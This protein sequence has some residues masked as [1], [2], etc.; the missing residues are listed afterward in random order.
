M[1]MQWHVSRERE[2][3]GP[4]NWEEFVLMLDAGTIKPGDL[5]WAEGLDGWIRADQINGLIIPIPPP[6]PLHDAEHILTSINSSTQTLPQTPDA[7]YEVQE[8]VSYQT[9]PV[10]K[11]KKTKAV[12]LV[13]ILIV[14][15]LTGVLFAAFRNLG[16]TDVQ[17][18]EIQSATE[19]KR[20]EINDNEEK[21]V[22]KSYL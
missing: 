9:G 11:T 21:S 4:F 13:V 20:K 5:I 7:G 15:L 12:I 17:V 1:S 6:P 2:H 18:T 22:A 16:N 14:I 3:L 19:V 8:Q 10:Q